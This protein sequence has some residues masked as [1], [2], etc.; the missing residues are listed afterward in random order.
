MNNKHKRKTFREFV[1]KKTRETK[2]QLGIVK[3]ILEQGGIT[4]SSYL[5]ESDPY[6][7]VVS[8]EKRLSFDGVRIYKV[9]KHMAFRVQKEAAT[10]PYG[11]AYALDVEEMYNDLISEDKYDEERA[12]KA[13]IKAVIAELKSFFAKSAEAE[14]QNDAEAA[15]GVDDPLSRVALQATGTDYAT[16]VTS[17]SFSRIP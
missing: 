7:F 11:E 3:K 14:K 5:Q 9:G 8:P 2:K 15:D 1:D 17:K 10:H 12:G 6:I 13:V 16:Q 4:V